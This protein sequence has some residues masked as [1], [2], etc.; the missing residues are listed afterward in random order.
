MEFIIGMSFVYILVLLVYNVNKP[1]LNNKDSDK[2][3]YN[4]KTY[5][6]AGVAGLQHNIENCNKWL[7]NSDEKSLDLFF[8]REPNNKFDKNAIAI[9]GKSNRYDKIKLGYLASFRAKEIVEDD[10]F[11]YVIPSLPEIQYDE[12]NNN[13]VNVFF[14]ILMEEN[15]LKELEEY[16]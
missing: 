2:P 3:K 15:K 8:E 13:R 4:Y 12:K 16:S 11:D 14:D 1:V 6:Q 9:Y 5:E 7:K 10:L